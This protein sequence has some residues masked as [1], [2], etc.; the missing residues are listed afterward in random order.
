MASRERVEPTHGTEE[1]Q[2]PSA[3]YVELDQRVGGATD[4]EVITCQPWIEYDHVRPLDQRAV[5]LA[6]SD[7]RVLR[8]RGTRARDHLVAGILEGTPQAFRL[9][10][11]RLDQQDRSLVGPRTL[12]SV[13]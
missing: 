7:A 13:N 6:P 8:R 3:T 10:V 9:S 12:S 5:A 4:P 11:I 1:D 2:R